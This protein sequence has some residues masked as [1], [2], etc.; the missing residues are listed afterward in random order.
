MSI[1]EKIL[2]LRN[3]ISD[4]ASNTGEVSP[5]TEGLEYGY[6]VGAH[7]MHYYGVVGKGS[8]PTSG[9]ILIPPMHNG[10]VVVGVHC[11]SLNGCENVIVP[12]TVVFID[13]D[14]FHNVRGNVYI[15]NSVHTVTGR[16]QGTL[17]SAFG[18]STARSFYVEWT[19]KPSGWAEDWNV[20]NEPGE[21]DFT[22]YTLTGCI[23]DLFELNNRRRY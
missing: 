9:T 21:G 3:A 20:Y 7:G 6:G 18:E 14:A 23:T 12:D 2:E 11:D 5:Y 16:L 1:A 19:T 15:P 10:K 4:L 17:L 8:A 13:A 22:T